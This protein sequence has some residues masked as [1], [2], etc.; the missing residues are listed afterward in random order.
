M[1]PADD[2]RLDHLDHLVVAIDGPSGSGKSSASRG[3]ARRLGLRYLDTGAM[4]RAITWWL[5]REGVRV[6]DAEA[7]AV[8]SAGPVLDV[9]TDPKGPTIAVDG[10]DVSRPIRS[11]EV[12]NAVSAVSAVPAVRT[13]LVD[14][15]REL[16]GAGGIVVE[17]RDIGT[18]VAPDADVKVFLTAHADERARRRAAEGL[19][20]ARVEVGLTRQE[21][22]R[23]DKVDSGRAASPLT[24]AADAVVVDTTALDLQQVIDQ[25]CALAVEQVGTAGRR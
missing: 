21:M 24:Q 15:Q 9:G 22:V 7:V 14:L 12:T 25:I 5:L 16:I 6:D 18:T 17:G 1:E 3:V 20:G 8:H 19:A 2:A 23:R 13:R 10:I 4:Y 11:R